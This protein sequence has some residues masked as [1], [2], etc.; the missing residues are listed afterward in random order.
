LSFILDFDTRTKQVSGVK[1]LR[2]SRNQQ[3]HVPPVGVLPQVLQYDAGGFIDMN[4][5]IFV[6][7]QHSYIVG[8]FGHGKEI[9]IAIL[10]FGLQ[11]FFN[12]LFQFVFKERPCQWAVCK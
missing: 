1:L 8:M 4:L 2:H 5:V 9:S 10:V 6:N 7:Q 3:A 12:M 11:I